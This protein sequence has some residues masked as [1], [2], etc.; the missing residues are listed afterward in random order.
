MEINSTARI[1]KPPSDYTLS[2]DFR[3]L[4][5]ARA[6]SD[7]AAAIA[8]GALPLV[9]IK[10]L[11]SG[12]LE[13]SAITSVSGLIGALLFLPLGPIVESHLKRPIMILAD[14]MRAL[15]LLSIPA[16]SAW[17]HLTFWHLLGASAGTAFLGIV[18]SGASE[19]NL[20]NMVPLE[21][22]T[23]AIGK[24][25]STFWI[26]NTLGPS[27]GGAIIQSLGITTT[28]IIQA[29]GLLFSA[30]GVARIK[31]PEPAVIKPEKQRF[32]T[33]VLAGFAKTRGHRILQPLFL[34]SVLFT[35]MIAWITPLEIVLLLK[36]LE[37]PAW[38]YGLALALPGAGGI[39][40]AWAAPKIA[41]RFDTFS[42]LKWSSI[43]RGIPVLVIPFVPA[44][45]QGF[46]MFTLANFS[47]FL[48]AGIYRPVYAS[49]RLQ[50]TDNA[51]VTRVAT[52]F[53]LS[54]RGVAAILAL[55]GGM[56]G[57]LI[58]VRAAIFIGGV[59]LLASSLIVPK[60]SGCPS[61]TR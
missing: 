59:L 46:M 38:Q 11:G 8:M 16:A 56:M 48:A 50:A 43:F 29:L 49:I 25:E 47:L 23:R 20:K 18:S 24:L 14:L 31:T 10:I 13:V 17:S 19:A 61:T 33:E 57:T 53:I 58:G 15:L 3:R 6:T 12:T 36:N 28:L 40:G 21:D 1:E 30:A 37:L 51:Y 55:A 60:R 26:F 4:W 41:D 39:L 5:L 27:V 35:G 52:S 9:A 2:P 32:L 42:T 22:R 7:A 45:T 44:G 34:N 54:S